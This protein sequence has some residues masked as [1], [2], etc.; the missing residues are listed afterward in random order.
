[1]AD[2]LKNFSEWQWYLWGVSCA[3]VGFFAYR[4]RRNPSLS[5]EQLMLTIAL[6]LASLFALVKVLLYLAANK[7]EM[8]TKLDWDGMMA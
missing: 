1:M 3:T 7:T 8:Q 6:S 2:L 4:K 5:T